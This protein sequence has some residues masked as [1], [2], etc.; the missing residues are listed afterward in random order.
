MPLLALVIV[1]VIILAMQ[2]GGRA[3]EIGKQF[4]AEYPGATIMIHTSEAAFTEQQEVVRA[5]LIIEGTILG[6]KPYW[7]VVGDDTIPRIHTEYA[8]RVD[9]VIKGDNNLL[10]K[11]I[12][13]ELS[14]GSLDGITA[15][16]ESIELTTGETVIM[17][18]GKDTN[19]I[20]GDAYSPLSVSKSVYKIENG[21]A[22]NKADDRSGSKDEIKKRI[23]DKLR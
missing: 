16:T 19:S 9:D 18:L 1:P 6:V 7:K 14:G 23:S 17:L 13:V 15:K 10:T 12:S 4:A 20:F 22:T 5:Q 8:V 2:D 3:D 21:Y 11:T